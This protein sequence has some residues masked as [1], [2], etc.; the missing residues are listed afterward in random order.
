MEKRGMDFEKMEQEVED[1]I[2]DVNL[3]LLDEK[4]GFIIK[5]YNTGYSITTYLS[6][7]VENI[8]KDYFKRA[9]KAKFILLTNL[10]QNDDATNAASSDGEEFDQFHFILNTYGR[11]REKLFISMKAYTRIPL[12]QN[13]FGRFLNT[14][15]KLKI[16]ELTSSINNNLTTVNRE[17]LYEILV[18]FF[19]K[20]EN[21]K[22]SADGLRRWTENY[23][24][25]I[26]VFMNSTSGFLY[27]KDNFAN[28]LEKYCEFFHS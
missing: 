17:L 5:N 27:N 22:N 2:Q 16:D 11:K 12:K 20:I 10:E 18:D 8:L 7:I 1:I 13:D 9:A 25:E 19:N 24:E 26:I 6:I 15:Y 28:F 4:A 23:I 21:K 14:P 3:R